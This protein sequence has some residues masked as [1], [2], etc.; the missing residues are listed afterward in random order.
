[1]Y[2]NKTKRITLEEIK[3]DLEDKKQSKPI[4]RNRVQFRLVK[5]YD[6]NKI[7]SSAFLTWDFDT[8]KEHSMF[9]I[10]DDSNNRIQILKGLNASSN[11]CA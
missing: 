10:A 9:E 5:K 11:F 6:F 4:G 8:G 3:L 7:E 1:M 2:K